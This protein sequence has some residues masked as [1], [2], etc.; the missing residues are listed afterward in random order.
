MSRESGFSRQLIGAWKVIPAYDPVHLDRWE[1]IVTH[2]FGAAFRRHECQLGLY[3][4]LGGGQK[5][6]MSTRID[7]N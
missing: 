3:G 7:L 4:G 1:I 6:V 5:T 2:D